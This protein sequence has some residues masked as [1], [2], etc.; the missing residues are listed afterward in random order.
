MGMDDNVLR[1][2]QTSEYGA[3][4]EGP[5]F[6][7]PYQGGSR[8]L[9]QP[10]EPQS[11]GQIPVGMGLGPYS[12]SP[13]PKRKFI[14]EGSMRSRKL[15]WN[16][17][18]TYDTPRIS[19]AP[20]SFG[21][22]SRNSL[23]TLDDTTFEYAKTGSDLPPRQPYKLQSVDR[24]PAGMGPC[25]ASPTPKRKFVAKG[26]VCP[27]NFPWNPVPTH[28]IPRISMA[29][30]SFNVASRDC[31]QTLNPTALKYAKTRS[32]RPPRQPYELQSVD[33]IPVGMGLS[34]PLGM[35]SAF[36]M[37]ERK[38]VAEGPAHPEKLPGNP[39][40]S[41]NSPMISMAPVSSNVASHDGLPPPDPPLLERAKNP[42]HG[43]VME[44]VFP[45]TDESSLDSIFNE[46][47]ETTIGV[48]MSNCT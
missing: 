30:A 31:F 36:P 16:P 12:A 5:T 21:A 45:P 40:S 43:K 10:H 9:P 3:Q 11:V 2:L 41:C 42:G 17:A 8:S 29:P 35:R 39:A 33:Q 1:P 27:K 28:D 13:T 48:Y 6:A 20:A 26:S 7:T 4:Y 38:F 18:P 19:M 24:I 46:S 44:E 47:T 32:D 37:A 22:A 34:K 23:Q 15:P 14:A 25:S